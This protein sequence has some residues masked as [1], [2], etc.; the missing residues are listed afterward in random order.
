V[1]KVRMSY[2]LV[3]CIYIDSPGFG[4]S[5]RP[6]GL[7]HAAE[8]VH[9]TRNKTVR[10]SWPAGCL[11]EMRARAD[12]AHH[13]RPVLGTGGILTHL[14]LRHEIS[15]EISPYGSIDVIKTEIYRIRTV[16]PFLRRFSIRYINLWEIPVSVFALAIKNGVPNFEFS[17]S[18][19]MI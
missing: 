14:K 4:G 19:T 12:E 2:E 11:L 7:M 10:A 15:R 18:T 16:E 13:V 17:G 8:I 6:P 3:N 5:Q 9:C 1:T